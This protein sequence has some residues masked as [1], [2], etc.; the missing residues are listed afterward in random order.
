MF[1]L[2]NPRVQASKS[3]PNPVSSTSANS[4]TL[5]LAKFFKTALTSKV[6]MSNV[7]KNYLVDQAVKEA[8]DKDVTKN[9][10]EKY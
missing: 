9:L 8:E 5:S 7:E 4:A 1:L 3:G 6:H 10:P 2:P